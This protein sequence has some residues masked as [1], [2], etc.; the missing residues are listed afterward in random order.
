MRFQFLVTRNLERG[1]KID[2]IN[3]LFFRRDYLAF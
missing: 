2:L 3:F 1:L